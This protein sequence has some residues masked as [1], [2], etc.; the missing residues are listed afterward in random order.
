MRNKKINIDTVTSWRIINAHHLNLS[1]LVLL[2]Q[3]GNIR[4]FRRTVLTN[5]REFLQRKH[6]FNRNTI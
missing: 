6:I 1:A 5:Q 3:G 2:Q 4:D